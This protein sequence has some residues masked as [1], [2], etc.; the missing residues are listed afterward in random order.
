MNKSTL[1]AEI[2]KRTKQTKVATENT[3][4]AFLQVIKEAL[5]REEE[6]QFIG[7]GKFIVVQRQATKGRNPRTREEI[8]IPPSKQAKFRPGKMLKEALNPAP[9]TPSIKETKET[10]KAGRVKKS[11]GKGRK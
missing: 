8:H 10:S 6:I 1:I 7:F 4:E 3:V 9:P 2:A 11:E 5:Q